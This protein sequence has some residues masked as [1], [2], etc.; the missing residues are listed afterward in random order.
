MNDSMDMENLKEIVRAALEEDHAWNDVT[1][2]L[3]DDRV[4]LEARMVAKEPGILAGIDAARLAFE[5]RDGGV[6]FESRL[7]DGAGLHAGA[8]IAVVKGSA[9]AVLS[10]ERTALNFVQRLSG[11]ATL[12]GKYV[13]RTA[14]SGIAILDTR[15]TTPL[16][17][18]L[19]KHAVRVG[20]G[21]NHRG[22]LESMILVKD[23]HIAAAG[24]E[25]I[26]AAIAS[27]TSGEP[28]EVEVDSLEMLPLVLSGPVDRIMLDNFPPEEARRAVETIRAH[29]AGRDAKRPEIELSGG[30]TL[31]NIA[32]YLIDGVD[33]ISVGALTASAPALDISL[34]VDVAP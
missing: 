17:R 18:S 29:A 13:E 21:R 27:R 22:D 5:L 8:L 10:A 24:L 34:E 4:L 32:D 3:V 26:L 1:S 30:I 11:I 16:L 7:E 9:R 15:K 12:T 25:N 31:D 2:Q 19:E 33:F 20:G 23:N 14:G 6:S 28:V